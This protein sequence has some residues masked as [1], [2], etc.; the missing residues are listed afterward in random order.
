MSELRLLESRYRRGHATPCTDFDVNEGKPRGRTVGR[1]YLDVSTTG[2]QWFWLNNRAPSP[3]ADRGY[4]PTRA[5]AMLTLK[6]R[7]RERG[8]LKPGECKSKRRSG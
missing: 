1:I 5:K 7:W 6:H 3:A 8:S 4:A 2:G